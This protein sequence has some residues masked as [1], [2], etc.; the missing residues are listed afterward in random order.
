MPACPLHSPTSLAPFG[1]TLDSS[2]STITLPSFVEQEYLNTT[3]S[4]M[5]A[6]PTRFSFQ[7]P[8]SHSM[9]TNSGY[10]L[11]SPS[12]FV[13]DRPL[14]P[15][16]AGVRP[17]S[18]P[19]TF[20]SVARPEIV[21]AGQPGTLE[22]TEQSGITSFRRDALL[23]LTIPAHTPSFLSG[24]HSF[25]SYNR[26]P[27]SDT[28]VVSNVSPWQ[29]SLES[30]QGCTPLALYPNDLTQPSS[31]CQSPVLGFSS[32]PSS[33]A[34]PDEKPSRVTSQATFSMSPVPSISAFPSPPDFTPG[35]RDRGLSIYSTYCQPFPI[36][37]LRENASV[38]GAETTSPSNKGQTSTPFP[39]ADTP[40]LMTT[41]NPYPVLFG[42]LHSDLM[43]RDN[44]SVMSDV[45]SRVS[46]MKRLSRVPL[47]PRQMHGGPKLPLWWTSHP[48]SE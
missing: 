40:R 20:K 5:L 29:L 30:P 16:W 11:P 41:V 27:F 22:T 14:P 28:G 36:A 37:T 21:G 46:S 44:A 35:P 34:S 33:Y 26:Y 13:S 24:H 19:A 45:F 42:H 25:P 23:P 31:S 17:E 8:R 43:A 10:D 15:Q 12:I 7:P 1:R 6:T 39:A 32:S 3:P 4:P 2:L 9:V 38:G 47:G 48:P 18:T